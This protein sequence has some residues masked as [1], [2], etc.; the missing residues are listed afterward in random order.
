[1]FSVIYA[2]LMNP[3]PYPSADRIVRLAVT[4]KEA[5]FQ[6]VA[7]NGPQLQQLQQVPGV[8]SLLAMYYQS[9]T[10][11]GHEVPEN[12][13]VISLIS[14][15]F[16]DLGVPPY[17]GRGLI[18]SDAIDGQDPQPVAVLSYKFWRKQFFG[19]PDAIGRTL[20]CIPAS[21]TDARSPVHVHGRLATEARRDECGG[22]RRASA[23]D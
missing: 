7:P 6:W 8:A 11:T 17:L 18:P 4:S 16:D 13:E 12:V 22:G 19:N 5:A 15:G 10:L 23:R 14:T 3:F 1:V 21:Q 2:A 9:M 20:Q